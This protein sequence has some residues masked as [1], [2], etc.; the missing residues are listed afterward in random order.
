[1][2]SPG[3]PDSVDDMDLRSL[4]LIATVCSAG[5]LSAAA[6]SLRISQPTLSKSIGRIERELGVRLFDRSGGSARPTALGEFVAARAEPLLQAASSLTREIQH[7]LQG[8]SGRLIIAAGPATR[9]HPLRDIIRRAAAA[10]PS[11]RIE[12]RQV[13]GPEA[14]R[15]VA[16]WLYDIAITNPETAEPYGDLIRVKLFEDRLAA[17]VRAG[18]PLISATELDAPALLE[19]PIASFRIGRYLRKRLGKLDSAQEDRLHAF[20]T[21]DSELLR[22]YILASDAVAWVP[23]YILSDELVHGEALELP[24]S[25][26]APFEC[27]LLTT[28]GHWTSPVVQAI[29][30]FARNAASAM[31]IAPD[32]M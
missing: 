1:M 3:P 32:E 12:T 2:S 9:V 28:P 8:E 7:H 15:G 20:L 5:S 23:R 14:A 11:L 13:R 4:E 10:F 16:E 29:A 22:D 21:D 19:Y 25:G 30:G 27:W 6:R 18:H 24:V 31:R 17:I 26:N